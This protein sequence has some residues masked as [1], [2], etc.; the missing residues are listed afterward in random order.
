MEYAILLSNGKQQSID[1]YNLDDSPGNFT[2]VGKEPTQIIYRLHYFHLHMLLKLK[3]TKHKTNKQTKTWE[4]QG[5]V[6]VARKA[7][8]VTEG[9]QM[10]Q[11]M[12]EG[13]ETRCYSCK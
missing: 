6:V 2:E 4:G 12:Q 9:K 5:R 1:I 13:Q 3:Q 11:V 7:N 10:N 8:D